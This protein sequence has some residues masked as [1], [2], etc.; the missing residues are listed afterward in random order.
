M[1]KHLPSK[2][3][4]KFKPQYLKKKKKK[5]NTKNGQQVWWHIPISGTQKEET[6][7]QGV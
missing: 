2:Y 7:G 5:Q 1:E 3:K 6:G 4:A